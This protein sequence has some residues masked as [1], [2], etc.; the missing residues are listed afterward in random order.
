MVRRLV[1]VARDDEPH[2]GAVQAGAVG[3]QEIDVGGKRALEG[4]VS[5]VG[6]GGGVVGR[7]AGGEGGG[8]E[9]EGTRCSIH[10][11]RGGGLLACCCPVQ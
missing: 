5:A 6:R 9:G 11:M 1:D 4:G 8:G 3:P 10:Q 2:V 7:A